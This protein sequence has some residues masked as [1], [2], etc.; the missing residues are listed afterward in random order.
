MKNIPRKE[1]DLKNESRA[2][3]GLRNSDLGDN[4]IIVQAFGDNL[5]PLRV[6]DG[7]F[8]IV[9]TEIPLRRIRYQFF[10]PPMVCMPV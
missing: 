9:K 5:E 2:I 6:F 10:L 7:D 3:S 8:L 1:L 4:F